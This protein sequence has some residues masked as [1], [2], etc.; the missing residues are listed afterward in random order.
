M[1]GKQKRKLMKKDS[2]D[3]METQR[4]KVE[5]FWTLDSLTKLLIQQSFGNSVIRKELY[6]Y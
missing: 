5:F 4:S 6:F 1:T 3:R 2:D